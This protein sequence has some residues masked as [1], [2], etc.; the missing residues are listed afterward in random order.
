MLEPRTL[1]E[2]FVS[3]A[4]A[5]RR[6]GIETPEL[7][8]RL[9]L[10]HAAG[11]T[12]EA[13]I[14]RSRE[15]LHPDGAARL[16]RALARRIAREPVSRILGT[17]EFYGR[18]FMVGAETLDPRPDTETLIEAALAH[19]ESRGG[20][21]LPLKLLDLGTGTGCILLTL[22]AEL[23]K[24]RGLGTDISEAALAFAA[25][26]AARLGVADRASFRAADWF[27]G[28]GGQFDFV[29]SNPPYLAHGEMESLADDVALYDPM[30][31]LYGGPDGLAAY[32]RI[33]ARAPAVIAPGGRLLV[34]IGAGQ[35]GAVA[36][37]LSMAGLEIEEIRADLAGRPRV[38]VARAVPQTP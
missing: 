21:H 15:Q 17:R 24:A 37:L 22:L 3:A 1:S 5:L 10:C 16:D 8:A 20:R 6:A 31:A 35:A 4:G 29:V 7:D 23:P 28:I 27:D 9:L 14:A 12:Y 32:R 18:T 34:E 33:A 19:A 13:L 38:I 25:Q 11:L 26:N 2:A 30:P 36:E